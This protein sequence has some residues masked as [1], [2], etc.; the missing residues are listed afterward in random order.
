MQYESTTLTTRNGLRARVARLSLYQLARS[1]WLNRKLVFELSRRELF[2]LHA[3]QLGGAVWLLVHPLLQF[4]TYAFLFTFVFKARIGNSGPEFYIIYLIAGLSPWL[5]TQ[6]SLIRGSQSL[7]SNANVVKK[8][9]FPTE[10]LV[11]KTVLTGF[12]I[13]SVLLS[14]GVVGAI[15]VFGMVPASFALLPF[16]IGCIGL[17]GLGLALFFSVVTAY[18]RDT[19]EV[20]RVFVMVNVYLIPV[21]Y[22]PEWVPERFQFVLWL[23]PFS[24]LV[25]CFQ[26]ALFFRQIIHPWSWIIFPTFSVAAFAFGATI[27][28][29][30]R[31]HVSSVL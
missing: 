27:F 8:V 9:M 5:L 23:N 22:L 7:I 17:L 10:V 28:M 2:D 3:G 15:L 12:V 6:D 4:S 29:R 30:L 24:H 19:F 25:W 14:L 18:L 16:A 21:M 31:Q 11:A 20:L 1:L 26:D 13:Q